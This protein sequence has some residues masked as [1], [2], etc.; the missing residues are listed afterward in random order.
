MKIG[1]TLDMSVAF[2]ANGM[3]QNIVFLHSL[4]KKAGN[5][6]F[7]ITHKKPEHTLS[8]SHDGMLLSDVLAD[9]KEYFD[10]LI[11]AGFD[12]LPEMYDELKKRNKNLKIVLVH[13]GNKLMDDIHYA[14]SAPDSNKVP[15]EKP[16]YLSQI[17]ISPH[18]EF[19]KE[20]LKSY[21][22][23][24]N[25]EVAPFIWDPFFIQDKIKELS[26]KNLSPF[27]DKDKASNICIF[28]PNISHIKNCI[29]PLAICEKLEQDRPG[30]IKS[31][32]CFSCD[33]L[34]TKMFFEKLMKRLHLLRKRDFCFFNNRW[35]SLNALSKFGSTVISHQSYNE[36][37]Y[38]HFET[39][40]LGLPLIHNSPRLQDLGYYYEEFDVK[41]GANQLYS[42]MINHETIKNEYLAQAREFI[43]PFSP[44]DQKNSN[45]YMF[46]LNEIK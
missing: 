6:C 33:K 1:I 21:Y 23:F 27:F 34:R 10:V 40:Y 46:L 42:A 11:I 24:N 3:Q 4:L 7:Y 16:K 29:I 12:L 15:L 14:I 45:K 2:W 5:E 36:L 35:G 9:E 37:N 25:I 17:W 26:L 18:H 39:L 38:S 41:M 32:N 22:N 43:S 8:K 19:S 44:Y 13:F 20:Y 31:I 30:K 28:E